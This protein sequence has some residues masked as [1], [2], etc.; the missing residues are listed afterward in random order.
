MTGAAPDRPGLGAPLLG[1]ALAAV[2]FARAFRGPPA[3]FWDRMTLNGFA[4]GG[5][6]LLARPGLARPRWRPSDLP[7]GL[8][9]AGILYGLFTFGDRLARRVLPFGG[10]EIEEIYDLRRQR[11]APEI[12]AR[13][14]AVIAPAEEIF[15]RGMLQGVLMRR[16]GR[17]RGAALANAA[18]TGVHLPSGNLTLTAAAGTAGAFW[19]ALHAAGIPLG[20]LVVS[21]VAW[22]V[23]IF[24]VAPTTRLRLERPDAG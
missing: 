17:W 21:H 7:I 24:L 16:L 19:S 1:I 23:W 2:G 15:W 5:L 22:D 8:G 9:S 18:Y 11:P 3:L 6:A 13:L 10:R 20:A 14:I 4:L 12:A